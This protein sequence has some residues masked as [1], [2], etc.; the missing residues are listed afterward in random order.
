MTRSRESPPA[1]AGGGE[2]HDDAALYSLLVSSVRDYAIFALD[3][4]G[5]VLTWNP[6]A[7]RFKGYSAS[8]II[9]KHF[10][11]FYPEDDIRAEKP[12]MELEVAA[13]VGRFEDEGWR[14]RKDGTRFW[15]NVVITALRAA[16][17]TLVGFGKVTRDLTARREAEEQA[18][19]LAAERA[20]HAEAERR[21]SELAQL[22]EALQQQAAELEAQTEEA[23]NLTEE[24]ELAN[25]ELNRA[26]ASAEERE[27][28]FRALANAIP[29]LAWM[30]EPD[31]STFWYNDR[32]YEYTGT[33]P[34][35]V[36]GWGWQAVHHPETQQPALERWRASIAT[37]APF[38]MEFPLRGADGGFRWFLTRVQPVRDGAGRVV[39]WFG[40]ST[41]I[42]VLR[43]A[44]ESAEAARADAERSRAEAEAASRA[45][46][47]F[48]AVMSHELRTPLNAIA[49]YAELMELGLRGPLTPEQ[50]RDLARIK[51][52]QKHLLGLISGVLDLNRVEAGRVT[53][54]LASLRIA[55]FLEDIAALMEPSALAKD[56]ALAVTDCSEA[57]LVEADPEKLRQILLN[58]L[59]NAIRHTP[60]GGRVTLEA[61]PLN[62]MIAIRVTDTGEGIAEDKLES[63]FEPFVQLD[64]SLTATREGIGLGLAI[65]RD[66]ARGMRGELSVESRLGIGSSFT[67][68]LPCATGRDDVV[69]T[70]TG[71][72]PRLR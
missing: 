67:L 58:L 5:H 3:A 51:N 55:A 17:G 1:D 60:N 48:L 72:Y 24:V 18:R 6:G 59:S 11:T 68:V 21:S 44:R 31:G 57:L 61:E 36:L 41:D 40:T 34:D 37:G 2:L 69:V 71:E 25:E 12:A 22:T 29:Q 30:A 15:A 13:R 8:E 28:Q 56:V 38:E 43:E 16:D 53:Y 46:T 10:S 19:E 50:Q 65:S 62:G 70:T 14:L 23:Q 35:E 64:R 7:E 45:K 63:I 52:S 26:L 9:G 39:R 49:G 27:Q 42:D 66:L 47:E 20:A 54:Q 33:T 32:W 4:Q